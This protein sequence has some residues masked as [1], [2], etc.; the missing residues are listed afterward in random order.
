MFKRLRRL[1]CLVGFGLL[2]FML[3]IHVA[4]ASTNPLVIGEVN[5]AGSSASTADEWIELWNTSDTPLSLAG[6]KLQGAGGDGIFFSTNDVI[7]AR[8]TFLV[9]NYSASDTKSIL[10]TMTNVVTTTV[11]LPN[12]KLDIRLVNADG[13]I[14][15]RAG[16]GHTPPSGSSGTHKSSMIRVTPLLDGTLK[17]AWVSANTSINFD[18]NTDALGTPGICDGCAAPIDLSSTIPPTASSTNVT[19]TEM[20]TI[21]TSSTEAIANT[22]TIVIVPD[23]DT[24]TQTA[25]SNTDTFIASTS[26]DIQNTTSTLEMT[27]ASSTQWIATSTEQTM[28]STS[29]ETT[30][31]ETLSLISNTTTTA[32]PLPIYMTKLSP[33]ASDGTEWIE[34]SGVTTSTDMAG[35]VMEDLTGPIFHFSST[36]QLLDA[37]LFKRI[38]LSGKHLNNSGD[39]ITLKDQTGALVDRTTYPTTKKDQ[40]WMRSD[41][42]SVWHLFP[43]DDPVPIVQIIRQTDLPLP[44]QK[45]PITEV[46]PIKIPTS[47]PR[48]T[49]IKPIIMS[50]KPFTIE[51]PLPTHVPPQKIKSPKPTPLS[52]KQKSSSHFVT[53][54][55]PRTINSFTMIDEALSGTRVRLMGTV[56]SVSKLLAQR[57]FVIQTPD[58]RGLLVLGNTHQPS[59]TYGSLIQVTGTLTMNDGGTTL[60]MLSADRWQVMKKFGETITPRAV[61]LGAPDQEDAWSLVDVTGT[62]Q[63]V[64][65]SLI[66]IDADGTPITLII[67]PVLHYRAQRILVGDIVHTRGLLDT[68]SDVAK[69]IPRRAEEIEI[70]SHKKVVMSTGPAQSNTP[71]W[72]PFGA[73]GATV[74]LSQGIKQVKRFREK[75]RLAKLLQRATQNLTQSNQQV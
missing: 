64:N 75:H 21:D 37:G 5:W 51:A 48:A 18:T 58:G 63:N 17:E 40:F 42:T 31:T 38:I 32:T 66:H 35:W 27:D 2:Y 28:M 8:A 34:L 36:T 41:D 14:I 26:T 30:S 25:I 59:P 72:M 39:T 46:K 33:N 54:I 22:S 12:D 4:L 13:V 70:V 15:D 65:G 7:P 11:S 10:D 52:K 3:F 29:T 71:P 19:S 62:V 24:L 53:R 57:Q 1:V 6:Y 74:A 20:V 60:R 69:I 67:K 43:V 61:E 73:A 9:S 55:V 50:T 56:A 47:A 45:Q 23:V 44:P 16:D 68:R 49:H